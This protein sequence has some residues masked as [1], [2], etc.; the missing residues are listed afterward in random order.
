MTNL[1]KS[2]LNFLAEQCV[3]AL[4]ISDREKQRDK[5][6][7]RERGGKEVLKDVFM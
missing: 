6:R 5:E 2:T 1:T 3:I 7:E 4:Q